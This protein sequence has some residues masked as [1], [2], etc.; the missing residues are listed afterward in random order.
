MASS[1]T[2]KVVD[3]PTLAAVEPV[4][5]RQLGPQRVVAVTELVGHGHRVDLGRHSAR[6]LEVEQATDH[7]LV[8]D[9]EIVDPHLLADR[10]PLLG[11]LGVDQVGHHRSG[12]APEEDVGERGVAPEH[13]SQ[14]EP[15]EQHHGGVDQHL[16]GG[17]GVPADH[18]PVGQRV[19]EVPRDQRGDVA[20]PP[21]PHETHWLDHGQPAVDQHPQRAVLG[22]GVGGVGLLQRVDPVVVAD[23]AHDVTTDAVGHG[24]Q[25]LVVPLGQGH[26]PRQVEEVRVPTVARAGRSTNARQPKG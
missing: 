11:G 5:A 24:H 12:V 21:G 2:S 14:V 17:R 15:D 22:F 16:S 7:V 4:G 9:L 20:R 19:V 1:S 25:P 18:V 8:G 26:G 23:E 13:P 3:A 10:R 6:R